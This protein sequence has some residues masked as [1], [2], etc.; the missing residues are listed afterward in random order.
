MAETRDIDCSTNIKFSDGVIVVNT[1][2]RPV[3][4]FL[5]D[6]PEKSS[7]VIVVTKT[8]DN[9]VNLVGH[10]GAEVNDVR[11]M[12]MGLRIRSTSFKLFND[13]N[14]KWRVM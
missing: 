7:N 13:G 5:H 2:N 11:I 12:I 10:N 4:L 6:I 1:R 3:I 8:G 14:G 9:P